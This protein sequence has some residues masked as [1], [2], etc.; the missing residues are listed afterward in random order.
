MQTLTEL[1]HKARTQSSF[2]QRGRCVLTIDQLITAIVFRDRSRL[3][4]VGQRLYNEVEA[5]RIRLGDDPR[6][7]SSAIDELNQ[8]RGLLVNL[9]WDEGVGFLTTTLRVQLVRHDADARS[10]R[11]KRA[12]DPEQ[13][14]RIRGQIFGCIL[15]LGACYGHGVINEMP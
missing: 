2:E 6:M 1:N 15:F 9:P 5:L 10:E 3:A 14:V 8:L 4:D 13:E 12:P 11:E 7:F